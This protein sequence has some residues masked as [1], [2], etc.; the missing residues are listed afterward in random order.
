MFMVYLKNH[1]MLLIKNQDGSPDLR[2]FNSTMREIIKTYVKQKNT[3]KRE[4]G[5]K[6]FLPYPTVNVTGIKTRESIKEALKDVDKIKELVIK[7]YPLNSEW[8]YS[9]PFAS[10]DKQV[11]QKIQS[12]KGRLVYRSPQSKDGVAEFI[13]STEGLVKTELKVEYNNDVSASGSKRKGTIKDSQIEDKMHID[14]KGELETSYSEINQKV[15][16]IK[17]LHVQTENLDN[18]YQQFLI[19]NELE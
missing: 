10:L 4:N 19:Q 17:T 9:S 1:R 13:E 7:L 3:I 15:V 6:D 16:D 8:D 12:K 11:R 18:E 14:V 2:S 5:E